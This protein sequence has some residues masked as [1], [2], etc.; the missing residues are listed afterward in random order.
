MIKSE[1]NSIV[2]DV[3]YNLRLAHFST[4]SW[5]GLYVLLIMSCLYFSIF[6]ANF[7]KSLTYCP[8]CCSFRLE[9]SYWVFE[10]V[11]L[12]LRMVWAFILCFHSHSVYP[13]I[14]HVIISLFPSSFSS[15]FFSPLCLTVSW[16]IEFKPKIRFRCLLALLKNE[17]LNCSSIG[18]PFLIKSVSSASSS[19]LPLAFPLFLD[20][21]SEKS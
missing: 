12:Y 7:P 2:Y 16:Q 17:R 20:R 14:P 18:S 1:F 4:L 10:E 21:Q 15:C 6:R 19:F 8:L 9:H 11:F 5:P 3:F 13:L